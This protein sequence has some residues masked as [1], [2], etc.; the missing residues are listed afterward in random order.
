MAHTTASRYQLNVE[1]YLN[2]TL[3]MTAY[4]SSFDSNSAVLVPA[5]EYFAVLVNQSQI[6]RQQDGN[7]GQIE[8]DIQVRL[9]YRFVTNEAEYLGSADT[10]TDSKAAL[11][12]LADEL[13]WRGKGAMTLTDPNSVLTIP[14]VEL[15]LT[16]VG[17]VIETEITVTLVKASV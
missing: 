13:F 16:R 7:A 9:L 12:I 2:G 10:P 8:L 11:L 6:I 1:T 5:T 15:T 14:D 17:R 4:P 3:G